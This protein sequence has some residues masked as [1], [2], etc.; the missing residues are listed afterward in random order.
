MNATHPAFMLLAQYD[1]WRRLGDG[2][3]RSGQRAELADLVP[4]FIVLA[5]IGIGATIAVQI[6]KRRDFSKSCNDPQKLFRQ[7]C[8]AHQLDYKTQRLL[9]RLA[10]ALEMPQPAALFVTPTAFAT[11]NLPAQL[12][13]EA[14]QINQ[15]GRRLF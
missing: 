6:Y 2:L 15:L 11:T 9:Q 8:V 3:H 10:T 12:R 7:L 4:F 5:I 1:R 13:N 14:K